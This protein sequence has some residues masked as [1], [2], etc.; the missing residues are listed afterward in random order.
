LFSE[1][2]ACFMLMSALVFGLLVRHLY[3]CTPLPKP[4]S[5]LARDQFF[6]LCSKQTQRKEHLA[7]HFCAFI[8]THTHSAAL[9]LLWLTL[10]FYNQACGD[11]I[12]E[13]CGLWG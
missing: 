3:V 2:A 9:A 10:S 7:N 1:L 4:V 12:T 5:R 8:H 11:V 6:A 13:A